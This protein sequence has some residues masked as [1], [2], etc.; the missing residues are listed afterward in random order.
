MEFEKYTIVELDSRLVNGFDTIF[1]G[2]RM[3]N[4]Y[5]ELLNQLP[6]EGWFRCKDVYW[7]FVMVGKLMKALVSIGKAEKR[8]VDDGMIKVPDMQWVPNGVTEPKEIEAFDKDGN[9]L[10]MVCNPRYWEQLRK[11]GVGGHWEPTTREVH[12][13]HSEYRL[14]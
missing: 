3:H 14:I 10:G 7:N 12:A 2:K 1:R 13:F 11:N 5:I 8:T 4:D 9:S 6:K